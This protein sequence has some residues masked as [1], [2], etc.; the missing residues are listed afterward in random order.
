MKNDDLGDRMKSYEQ[1]EAGRRAMPLLPICARIDGRGFS[2]WTRNLDRPY[3][4]RLSNLMVETVKF[5]VDETHAKIGYTQSDEI[6]LVW[7]QS[8]E[9]Q[10]FFDGKIQKLTSVLASLATAEFNRL[11]PKM[12]M[13]GHVERVGPAVF[14]CRV[15]TVPNET[16]AANTLL[17]RE[18]DATKNSISMAAR[19]YYSHKEL[20]GKSGSEMQ[21][22]LHQKGV[23]WNDYPDFFKRGTFVQRKTFQRELEPEVLAKIPEKNRPAPGT[24]VTRSMVVKIDMPPFTKVTNRENVI[25]RG[26]APALA[27]GR[28]ARAV[29]FDKETLD[30]LASMPQPPHDEY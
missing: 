28:L 12:L 16:E 5:L 9:S 22:M 20:H 15:W 7:G 19:N 29:T 11:A 10:V 23:N 25:F 4:Q 8:I 24:M 6:S 17:W 26:E 21:E 27:D 3:D 2:K 30:M 18:K 1:V 14:D 13:T